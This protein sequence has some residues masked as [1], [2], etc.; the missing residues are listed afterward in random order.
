MYFVAA[1][2]NV[3]PN[4]TIVS[5]LPKAG[6]AIIPLEKPKGTVQALVPRTDAGGVVFTDYYAL[7]SNTVEV[8]ATT[9][10]M[11]TTSLASI[12]FMGGYMNAGSVLTVDLDG[13][14]LFF[15]G[16]PGLLALAKDGRS[17]HSMPPFR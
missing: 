6:G 4:T 13:S 17:P 9:L 1:I 7:G 3:G 8:R 15:P 2:I 16:A 5:A 11:Q 10:T 14:R 12:S